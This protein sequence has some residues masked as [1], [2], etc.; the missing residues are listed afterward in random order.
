MDFDAAVA[1]FTRKKQA[2]TRGDEKR[3][4][5]VAVLK[6]YNELKYAPAVN[7]VRKEREITQELIDKKKE[8]K[9]E[10]EKISNVDD[11]TADL[12]GFI[13]IDFTPKPRGTRGK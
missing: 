5:Y 8:Q 4:A 9:R 12:V 3:V 10:M 2:Q 1:A 6:E 13:D 7:G 11:V